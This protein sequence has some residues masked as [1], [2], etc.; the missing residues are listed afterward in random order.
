MLEALLVVHILICIALIGSILLQRSEGG[1]A[2]G[3]GGGP[4]SVMSGRAAANFMTRTTGV[5]ALL[6]FLT[7]ATLTVLSGGVKNKAGSV[8]SDDKGKNTPITAPV[9]NNVAN[10]VGAIPASTAAP[11]A[12]E[13]SAIKAQRAQETGNAVANAT[14][15]AATNSVNNQK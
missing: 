4:G 12:F 8:M 9:T 2:L 3:I 10:N 5:L 14:V 7:S 13:T 15:N 11:S 1:G 6:F